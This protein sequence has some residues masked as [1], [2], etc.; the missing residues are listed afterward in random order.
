M[1]EKFLSFIWQSKLFHPNIEIDNEKLEII[2]PGE[3]NTDAGPDFLNTKI[4]IG[5]TTWVGNAEIH[6][7]SSDWNSHNH[8]KN[9]AFDNV[10]L[11]IV[12]KKD[13]EI[14]TS[15]GR[16]IPTLELKYNK[17]IWEKYTELTQNTTWVQCENALQTI[18]PI[19]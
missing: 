4:K 2:H 6:I 16:K 8:Y 13:K 9:S 17:T 19:T 12:S 14:Y 15:K 10:I 18:D 1:T 5:N 3:L 11:H 7:N